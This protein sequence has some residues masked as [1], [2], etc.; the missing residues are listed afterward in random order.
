[1]PL[2]L[3]VALSSLRAHRLR[4]VLAMLG[5]FL[6]ALAL[7]GVQHTSMAMVR[8]AEMEVEKFGPNL[9]IAQAGQVH[10]SR[11]GT[12]RQG[13]AAKTFTL[14][15]AEA[16][17][18]SLPNVAAW[19]PFAS[20]QL[21]IRAG[22]HTVPCRLVATWPA[23][24]EVRSFRPALGRFF[25]EA[26]NEAR[27]KV[28]VLGRKIAQRLFGRPAKAVGREVIIATGSYRV[29][30]VM[31]EKGRDLAGD[32]Q[33]ESVL[34]PLNTYLR[35]AANQ[36]W[37]SGVYMQ[38]APGTE[39]ENLKESAARLLR[40]RHA[41][42]PVEKDDFSLITAK[43]SIKLQKQALDLVFTLGVISSSVSF[44][45]GGL[46]ILSI[47]VLLVRA[48]R[49]EIGVRRALGAKR[50]DIVRQFLTEA[51]LMS[52]AGGL[53]GVA[54]SLML[55]VS[56]AVAGIFPFVFDPGLVLGALAGS[57]ALGVAAGAYPAA[58]AAKV[59]I[60]DVLREN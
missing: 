1:M 46:G 18:G 53:F 30:G 22:A 41:I 16:L 32:D 20:T 7:T 49:L 11:S 26:E 59:A 60:L 45:V 19:A 24:M 15:D 54:A 51:A 48:R 17:A 36:D 39:G 43:E 47:M 14:A 23:F 57:A 3:R 55:T 52:G 13:A 2:S 44:A 33:D 31:E 38:L 27:A 29:L 12:L 21:P 4:A 56:L 28:V 9:F 37:I 40:A 34:M 58:Q 35:R 8:K 25:S 5:V 10:F 50:R 42:G 6:G